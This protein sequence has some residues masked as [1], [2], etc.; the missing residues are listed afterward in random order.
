VLLW[1][2]G[3]HEPA[4]VTDAGN[5]TY[6]RDR[7]WRVVG[8]APSPRRLRR[9]K[10]AGLQGLNVGSIRGQVGVYGRPRI[11]PHAGKI[12]RQGPTESARPFTTSADSTRCWHDSIRTFPMAKFGNT[13]TGEHVP[14]HR[15]P[16]SAP[17][18]SKVG[19]R[20]HES[21]HQG[22]VRLSRSHTLS[23]VTVDGKPWKIS[24]LVQTA[25]TAPSCRF[26]GH[27]ASTPPKE[28]QPRDALRRSDRFP[29]K[30]DALYLF[31]PR[32][33]WEVAPQGR[34]GRPKARFFKFQI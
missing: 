23:L 25:T 15:H 24:R 10:G 2:W 4:S 26:S 22:V 18:S 19:L 16:I 6:P 14:G 30:G 29:E 21:V 7:L 28:D 31:P 17:I 20:G 11:R 9:E 5:V 27:A 1:A 13:E 32:S 34:G 3:R 8:R 12:A 33:C